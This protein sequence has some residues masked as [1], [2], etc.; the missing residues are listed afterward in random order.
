MAKVNTP[1][2]YPKAQAKR[3]ARMEE[4][5]AAYG[6]EDVPTLKEAQGRVR[7]ASGTLRM[8]RQESAAF[9][10]RLQ[11]IKLEKS[12]LRAA[13]RNK[14]AADLVVP[15]E[16]DYPKPPDFRTF[17]RE[18]LGRPVAKHQ[19]HLVD[20]WEDE[21][22]RFVIMLGPP[23]MGKDTTA[24]DFVLYDVA[25]SRWRRDDK[26]VAWMMESEDFSKRRIK[27]RLSPYLYSPSVYRNAPDGPDVSVPTKSMIDDYG[28]FRWK[29]GMRWDD[30]TEVERT[31]WNSSEIYFIQPDSAPEADP[32]L[33][34]TGVDG[35]VY[36]S[37]IDRLYLSDPFTAENQT[38]TQPPKQMNFVKGTLRT[39]LDEKGRGMFLGT[40][41]RDGDNW[42]KT[43]EYF[44][45][46]ARV[47]YESADGQYTKYSN[48]V[49]TIIIPA[50]QY[51][52]KGNEV[53][54]WPERFP[55]DNHLR[56]PDG[57]MISAA[58]VT[59]EE[60]DKLM[61]TSVGAEF[62]GGLRETREADPVA[63][64]TMYQQSPPTNVGGEFTDLVLDHC[65]DPSRTLG[66]HKPGELLVL[67][68]D[69]ARSA[70]AAYTVWGYDP[71]EDV[72]TVVD[73]FYGEKLGVAGIKN[74]LILAPARQYMPRAMVYEINQQSAVL[75]I[76]E[77][78]RELKQMSV[79]IVRHKT[80][81]YNRNQGE[82]SVASMVFDMRDGRIRFPA[83]TKADR[84]RMQLFKQ[85]FKT[86][87]AREL[88]K[89]QGNQSTRHL[90]PDDICMSAWAGWVYIKDELRRKSRRPRVSVKSI[91]E[92]LRRRW[93]ARTP[94]T[95]TRKELAA[96]GTPPTSDLHSLYYGEDITDEGY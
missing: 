33:W 40:R 92:G 21:T 72:A 20:A 44:I 25:L 71:D 84:E 22:N 12:A 49:A 63:F 5:L 27:N 89:A 14:E 54:Y 77:I 39:R 1:P 79:Q 50:I 78:Q 41:V 60:W 29:K 66:R 93:K 9:E 30:G 7:L 59:E 35:A 87:D 90:G 80:H 4:F 17:R 11:A 83:A 53:S 8:W 75:E 47:V 96:S 52:E 24:G 61:M 69:P 42:A 26:R 28:P 48:G 2:T 68:V 31:T 65:D 88:A 58:S 94:N 57:E 95:L 43:L 46:N 55:L 56:M 91:P 10:N 36:G 64:A 23:G 13:K 37:R 32:N 74:E 81:Q 3:A 34:A 70:G 85:H 15:V 6:R 19:E 62:I 51:D 38:G 18:Y 67:S 86:W 16:R 76:E 45:G 73:F 82:V